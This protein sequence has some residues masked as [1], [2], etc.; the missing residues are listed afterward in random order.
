[1]EGAKGIAVAVAVECGGRVRSWRLAA[2]VADTWKG[3]SNLAGLSS[4]VT[5]VTVTHAI[6]SPS[7]QQL[8]W[9]ERSVCGTRRASVKGRARTRACW[10]RRGLEGERLVVHTCA[11]VSGTTHLRVVGAEPM[12]P[13][14]HESRWRCARSQLL[15]ELAP[16]SKLC[17]QGASGN[18]GPHA[19][20]TQRVGGAEPS[21]LSPPRP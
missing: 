10:S 20:H 17:H 9:L 14:A 1:M 6:S 12:C 8:N 5:F 7:P 18:A 3:F 19:Y 2:V 16:V 13:R 15:P 21:T 11:C 4:T